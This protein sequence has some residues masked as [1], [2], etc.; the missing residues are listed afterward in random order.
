M[1]IPMQGAWT[2]SVKSREGFSSPQRFIISSAATGNGTYAGDVATAPVA[3][4]GDAWEITI[5]HNPGSGFVDSF[6]QIRFPTT[7]GGSYRFDIQ[8][9][10]DNIDPNF[11]DLVLTC[12]TPVTGL[13]FLLYGNVSWFSGCLY[14]PCFPPY[15]LL[16]DSAAALADALTRPALRAVI[17][18]LYPER[19]P[20]RPG[21]IPD[22]A[23]F[24]SLLLP[25][26]GRTALP[27]KLANLANRISGAIQGVTAARALDM[28][29]AVSPAISASS[30]T[31]VTQALATNPSAIL[32]QS[33]LAG[34]VAKLGSCQTGAMP[35]YLLRFQDYDRTAAELAGG[36]Y[37]GTGTRRNLGVAT[38]DRNGNY[39]FRFS[40]SFGDILEE[41][42]GPGEDPSG[43]F[44]P[45]VIVQVLDSSA[46]SG[47]LYETTPFFNTPNLRRIN[48]CV[49]KDMVQV[50]G[51]CTDGQIIQSIGN[52]TVGPDTTASHA[53]APRTTANTWLDANGIITSGSGLGPAVDCAAWYGGLYFYA[54]LND[55]AVSYYTIR[56]GRPGSVLQFVSEDYSPYHR[57]PAPVYWVQQSVGPTTRSLE[58]DGAFQN[59][60]SYLNIETQPAHDW[61]DRWK[62]VK[63]VLSS[64]IYQTALGGPGTVVFRIQ[65]YRDN[66]TPVAGADESI[67]LYIDNNGV[68]QYLDPQLTMVTI[69]HGNISQGD[70]AL[71]T[72]PPDQQDAP[73]AISFRSN[74]YQGFMSSYAI[75]MDKGSTGL[76][77]IKHVSG[78][79][80][81]N[82]YSAPVKGT[83]CTSFNGTL[84]DPHYGSP[85]ANEV[86]ALVGPQTGNWLL[87]AQTFCAF[88][89]NLTSTVRV[90]DGQTAYPSYTSTPIL[91]G[92]KAG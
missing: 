9:N 35:Q 68:D 6:D 22:P 4:T 92:I 34:I 61:M 24:R 21:P 55:P 23:P 84:D 53:G 10:D 83:P 42:L 44:L 1:S 76:F 2:V 69:N 77:N 17:Q 36:S 65:G 80:N 59:V 51:G 79:L 86:T 87:P 41:I 56:F 32:K 15:Y 60:P 20:V 16:I 88:S 91:I 72:V 39:I 28:A 3:V 58:V 67:A 73:I 5:Q 7:S 11:D 52:I 62:L 29:A 19:I 38:T 57:A 49:P 33:A 37:T 81:G 46:P 90:T 45:D 40:L 31:P 50:P 26:E 71:F 48:V 25:I 13:D 63:M 18:T 27:A 64:G 30:V 12:S 47:V 8:A 74:Q 89:I 54:C 70:C 43:S 82:S 78:G 66:G 75:Q 14:N 85:I